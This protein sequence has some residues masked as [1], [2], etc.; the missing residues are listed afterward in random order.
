MENPYNISSHSLQ[1][2]EN[3]EWKLMGIKIPCSKHWAIQGVLWRGGGCLVGEWPLL[4]LLH[5]DSLSIQAI[6]QVGMMKEFTIG[7]SLYRR[8]RWS[9]GDRGF[10][11]LGHFRFVEESLA[12]WRGGRCCRSIS[13]RRRLWKLWPTTEWWLWS[14]RQDPG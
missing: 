3:F 7:G 11:S 14:A 13:T 1:Q 12:W 9:R 10:W 2:R 5:E 8:W 4:V 6:V